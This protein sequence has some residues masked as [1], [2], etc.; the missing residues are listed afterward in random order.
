M[1][2]IFNENSVFRV[3]FCSSLWNYWRRKKKVKNKMVN[4][5]NVVE[6][7]YKKDA[8]VFKFPQKDPELKEKWFKFL[9]RKDLPQENYIFICEHY[10][11]EKYLK[12]RKW[13][14]NKVTNVIESHPYNLTPLRKA[15]TKRIFRPDEFN[16][17]S[18]KNLEV[19]D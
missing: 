15:P 7:K 5:C 14:P 6:C 19:K 17:T 13:S 16:S 8:A 1:V 10:F 18:Y 11:E 4:R 2:Y 12:K 3:L 9:N